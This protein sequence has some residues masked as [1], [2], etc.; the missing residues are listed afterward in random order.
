MN[1][2]RGI[3]GRLSWRGFL[4]AESVAAVLSITRWL[5]VM[6]EP[7]QFGYITR[8]ALT[9]AACAAYLWLGIATADEWV[10]RGASKRRAYWTALMAASIAG[11]LTRFAGRVGEHSL[12]HTLL[13]IVSNTSEVALYGGLAMWVYIN[14]TEARQMQ[15]RLRAFELKRAQAERSV[16]DSRLAAIRVQVDLPKVFTALSEIRD[17][18]AAADA[19]ADENLDRLIERLREI[20]KAPAP[21]AQP[22]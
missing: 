3:A 21:A 11:G 1:F 4:I 5:D 19:R 18:Y 22:A 17:G 20:D 16:I 2:L 14:R 13:Y 10:G 12:P 15:Q 6:N 8:F 7:G 9:K